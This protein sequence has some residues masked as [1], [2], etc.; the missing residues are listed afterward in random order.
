MYTLV[1]IAGLNTVLSA[2]YYLKV[3]KVMIL[4]RPEGA[5]EGRPVTPVAAPVG[6]A[7]Y[8]MVLAAMVVLFP[9]LIPIWDQLDAASR[10]GVD[11]FY[12]VPAPANHQQAEVRR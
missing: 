4:D 3:L 11:R 9:V 7:L 12:K 6:A 5:E 10:Q 2:V 1:V 8:G